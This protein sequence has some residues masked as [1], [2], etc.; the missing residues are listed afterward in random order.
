MDG[1]VGRRDGAVGRRDGAIDC[2]DGAVGRRD[3]GIWTKGGRR[4]VARIQ[5][6]DKETYNTY[7]TPHAKQHRM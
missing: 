1:A 5:T 3:Q 2:R 6:R 7:V 4:T